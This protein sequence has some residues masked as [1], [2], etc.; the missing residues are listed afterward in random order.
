MDKVKAA[1]KSA[2]IADA[3]L[4]VTADDE[5]NAPE[6]QMHALQNVAASAS[7]SVA[8]EVAAR[9]AQRL[10]SESGATAIQLK[11]LATIQTLLPAPI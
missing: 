1:K 9:L 11:G 2:E 10:R 7:E 6:R 3:L 5:G 4:V 8:S